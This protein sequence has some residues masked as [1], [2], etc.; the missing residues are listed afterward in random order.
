M[1]GLKTNSSLLKV[2]IYVA[3]KSAELDVILLGWALILGAN[4]GGNLTPVGSP[5]NVLGIN[6][7]AKRGTHVG[8]GEWKLPALMVVFQVAIGAIILVIASVLFF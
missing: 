3:G 2:P 5:S 1:S 4:L 8:W 7:L 6:I